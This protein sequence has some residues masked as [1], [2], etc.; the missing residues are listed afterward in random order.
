[1]PGG[2]RCFAAIFE[3][4][5]GI[6]PQG[7]ATYALASASVPAMPLHLGARAQVG[8]RARFVAA[9]N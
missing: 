9:F 3:A 1:M 8:G 7:D 6:V 2:R 4:A 5:G